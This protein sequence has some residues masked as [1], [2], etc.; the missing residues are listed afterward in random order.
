MNYHGTTDID[1]RYLQN[2]VA[3]HYWLHWCAAEN[4]SWFPCGYFRGLITK[5]STITLITIYAHYSQ[6]FHNILLHWRL[7]WL[8]GKRPKL[9]EHKFEGNQCPSFGDFTSILLFYFSEVVIIMLWITKNCIDEAWKLGLIVWS[10]I[11]TYLVKHDS[12][13]AGNKRYE[14]SLQRPKYMTSWL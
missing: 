8:G 10:Q 12:W 14:Q 1:T 5:V 7:W 2:M 13:H 3:S 11:L 9:R 6:N 4:I